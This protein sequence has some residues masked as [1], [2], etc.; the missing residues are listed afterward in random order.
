[1]GIFTKDTKEQKTEEKVAQTPPQKVLPK[2]KRVLLA[3]RVTE[4][5][6][7][8]A[9]QNTYTFEVEKGAN[10]KQIAS[11]VK[12]VYGVTPIKI[13][14]VRLPYKKVK[15]QVNVGFKGGVKK[16]YVTLKKGDSIELF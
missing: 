11:A 8:L 16:A 10:K 14:T 2:G 12:D 13:R 7:V 15:R 5:A 1:M 3:P 4:K 9:E 6:A